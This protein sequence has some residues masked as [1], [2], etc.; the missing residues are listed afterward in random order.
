MR[1]AGGLK[2][3]EF[4]RDLWFKVRDLRFFFD[5]SFPSAQSDWLECLSGIYGLGFR[6]Q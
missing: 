5:T 1:L 4:I 3:W 2:V 6:V